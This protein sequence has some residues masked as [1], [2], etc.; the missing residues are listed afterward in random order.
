MRLQTPTR[1]SGRRSGATHRSARNLDPPVPDPAGRGIG[2]HGKGGALGHGLLLKP[3]RQPTDPP[4][5]I[6]V[7]VQ[8]QVGAPFGA[9]VLD[10]R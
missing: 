10:G 4:L 6:G 3:Y 2:D 5:H 7:R 1:V 8:H 9:L